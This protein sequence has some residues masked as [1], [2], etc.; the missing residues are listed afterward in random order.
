MTSWNSFYRRSEKRGPSPLLSEALRHIEDQG[1]RHAID[2]GCGA[3]FEAQQLVQAGWTVLAIDR[4]PEAIARTASACSGADDGVLTTWLMD[5]ERL[6]E[7]PASGL[8]HAGLALPFCR[9]DRF[10]R[11][12]DQIRQAL[13]P[14][15]VFVGHLFGVRHG[16]ATHS[17]LTFHTEHEIRSMCEGLDVLRLRESESSIDGDAGSLNWHR[18]DLIARKPFHHP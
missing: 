13:R 9:P 1:C 7:L 4:E 11:L 2:L 3:G 15:G 16:W 12:W 5:F 18:F 6:P 17:H 14:G 10:G 8:I